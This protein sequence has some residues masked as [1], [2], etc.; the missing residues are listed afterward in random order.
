MRPKGG[1]KRMKRLIS[2]VLLAGLLLAIAVPGLSASPAYI[3]AGEA[4]TIYESADTAAEALRQLMPGEAFDLLGSSP[5]WAGVRVL[6]ESGETVEGWVKS[7]RLR[8]KTLEDGFRHAVVAPAEPGA[9]PA[10]LTHARS[11]A[12]SL[13]RYY[14]G[15]VARVL[16]QPDKGWVKLGIGTLE[17]Y[18]KAENL[19][20]DPLPGAVADVLPRVSVAYKDGSSLT[21]R[22]AQSFKSEKIGAYR[23]GTQ[24]R[25]LGFTDDFAQVIAPDGRLGFMMAWGL[26]PQPY[27]ATMPAADVGQGSPE[28]ESPAQPIATPPPHAYTTSIANIGG[29]G[30]HLRRKSSA[31]SET[32]GMYPNGTQVYVLKYREYW[33]QVWVDGKTGWMMT[34]LLQGTNQPE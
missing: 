7:I 25:V 29:E 11:N 23:N 14:P 21:M 26:D 3:N 12:D 5:E 17:G 20:F 8:P 1:L 13:G 31:K 33:C 16:S 30:A 32:Q 9:L 28:A 10:L 6:T 18:M 34:K 15:A 24:V 22:G 27:A 2:M 19:A 4:L